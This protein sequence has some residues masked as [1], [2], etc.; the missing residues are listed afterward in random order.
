ME[1]LTVALPKGRLQDEV[2][3]LFAAAGYP[4]TFDSSRKLV[5]EDETGRLRFILSKPV[6]V[7][8]YVEYGAA[9][10]GVAGLDVLREEN[11]DVYEPLGLDVGHC[12]LVLA[13]PAETRGRNLRMATNLRVATKFPRMARD[14]FQRRG[15][16][17]ELIHLNGSIELAPAVGLADVL[18]D[19]V[20]TGRT[21]KENGLIELETILES[22]AMLVVN[23]ASHKLNFGPMQ[24]LIS[25]IGAEVARRQSEEGAE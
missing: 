7:P 2:L 17:A 9:A 5:F 1:Q 12:R 15:I 18:V 6:D 19:L 22:Q 10:I 4:T 23:R 20:Q 3:A 11:R 24:E 13:G 21:L 8:I 25:S 14:F 16:T